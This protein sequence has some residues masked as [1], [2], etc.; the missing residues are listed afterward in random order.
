MAAL[1]TYTVL[2]V[3]EKLREEAWAA[4]DRDARE[5]I[6]WSAGFVE[7]LIISEETS[8]TDTRE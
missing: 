4:A 3:A 1:D 5:W 8:S 2:V 7:R 6:G